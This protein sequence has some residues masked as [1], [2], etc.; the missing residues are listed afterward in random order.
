MLEYDCILSNYDSIFGCSLSGATV[1]TG[2]KVSQK[3]T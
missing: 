3:A 1:G 2:P